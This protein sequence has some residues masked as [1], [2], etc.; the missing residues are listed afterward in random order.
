[1]RILIINPFGI[2][3]VLF[4]TPLVRAIRQAFPSSVIGYLCNRRTETILRANPALDELFVYE[5][6]EVVALWKRSRWQGLRALVD[7]LR[8]IRQAHFT[9]AI[10][11]SLGARYAF[12]LKCLGV[13]QR[14]GLNFRNRGRFLTEALELDGYH[15]EHVI[16]TYDR[17]LWFLGIRP[18]EQGPEL[19]ISEAAVHWA[20][21]WLAEH[22][23]DPSRPLIGIVPAG[24]VSWGISA[25]FRRWRME[26]FA[27]VGSALMARHQ[28]QVV[29]FG[30]AS[31]QAMCQAVARLMDRPPVDVSGHTTL[32]QFVGL[33]SRMHLVICNDGGPLHLAVSQGT[34]TV[35][36]FGP[37]DPQVY[38]PFSTGAA[39]HRIIAKPELPCRPCY[40]QFKLPPCP[41]E[42]ACITQIEPAEVLEACEELLSVHA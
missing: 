23:L 34:P 8:R 26:G 33:L 39:R 10:D 29:L 9:L 12:I 17:F 22:H 16:A 21:T 6:D 4:T 27:E 24:G 41:Y 35:S 14:I 5:K 18:G 20:E 32:E 2:G 28:A 30:E 13:S 19:P 15:G 42:R 31:D 40:H 3:D 37:V 38:G 7:L 1:M 36:I 25:P 11:L